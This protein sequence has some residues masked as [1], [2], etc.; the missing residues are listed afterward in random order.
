MDYVG[1]PPAAAVNVFTM[2]TGNS[3]GTIP[4]YDSG[5]PVDFAFHRQVNDVSS[6]N[7]S[8]RIIQTRKLI[9]NDTAAVANDNNNTFDSNVGWAK[10]NGADSNFQSWMWKRGQGMDVVNYTGN[11]SNAQ[12]SYHAQC[13]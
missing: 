3:S 9:T 2:D 7:T 1:K 6:W 4:T 10:N 11:G 5:F 8:A 13:S 12:G